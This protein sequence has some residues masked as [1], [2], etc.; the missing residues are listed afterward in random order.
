MDSKKTFFGVLILFAVSFF[1]RFYFAYFNKIIL[2][3]P[4]ELRYLH[5]AQNFAELKGLVI[6]NLPTNFQ[7]ILYPLFLSPAFCFENIATQ[8][9]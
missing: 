4:D 6:Y 1:T 8:Q 9:F 2:I 3:Y 7:K 5:L